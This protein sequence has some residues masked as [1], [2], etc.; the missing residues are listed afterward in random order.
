LRY[1]RTPPP[2]G[3]LTKY[4]ILR[5]RFADIL[6]D[7]MRAALLR[8]HGYSVDVIE[9]V[10]AKHTPRN[11]LIRARRTGILPAADLRQKYDSLVSEWGVTPY[12]ATLLPPLLPA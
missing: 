7:A 4:P 12:L 10:D 11:T 6:T 9:F 3:L 1:P 8:L 5:E 2:Y